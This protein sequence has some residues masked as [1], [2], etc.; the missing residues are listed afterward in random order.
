MRTISIEKSK[1]NLNLTIEIG[2]IEYQSRLLY[3]LGCTYTINFKSN[4]LSNKVV[5]KPPNEYSLVKYVTTV[6]FF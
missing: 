4:I 1:C 3:Y 2:K 6:F 5:I